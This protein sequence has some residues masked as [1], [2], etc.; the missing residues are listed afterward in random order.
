MKRSNKYSSIV[1]LTLLLVIGPLA[2]ALWQARPAWPESRTVFA[3]PAVNLNRDDAKELER[4]RGIG[5]KTAQRIVLY[6]REHGPFRSVDELT[7]I[8]GIGG[9]TLE[10]IRD[11]VTI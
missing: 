4:V 3:G 9:K 10:K 6:R 1:W 5:P 7:E 2:G 8:K 11:Q